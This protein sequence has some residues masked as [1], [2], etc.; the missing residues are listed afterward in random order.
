[1]SD[2]ERSAMKAKSEI[3]TMA[4]SV[5]SLSC[6]FL[7]EVKDGGNIDFYWKPLLLIWLALTASSFVIKR[8]NKSF[9]FI[10]KAWWIQIVMPI[11]LFF[12]S[13][14]LEV[15]YKPRPITMHFQTTEPNQR[16]QTI[17]QRCPSGSREILVRYV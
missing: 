4:C 9:I 10:R 11:V 17:P 16:L 14:G 15:I 6:I 5:L 1:M 8:E 7:V 3:A 2:P 12:I 13:C